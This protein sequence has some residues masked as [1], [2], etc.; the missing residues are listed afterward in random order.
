MKK[1]LVL[2]LLA[3]GGFV[4]YRVWMTPEKRACSRLAELCERPPAEAEACERESRPWMESLSTDERTR[5]GTCVSG[6]TSC[7]GA[8]GCFAGSGLRSLGDGVGKAVGDF[9]KSVGEQLKR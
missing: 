2:V 1:L 8:L 5:L 7:A 6:A 4:G 9:M 3:G